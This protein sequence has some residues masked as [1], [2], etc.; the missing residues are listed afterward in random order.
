MIEVMEFAKTNLVS[1]ELKNIQKD[2]NSLGS[3]TCYLMGESKDSRVLMSEDRL[4]ERS[5][6]KIK[7]ELNLTTTE[8]T[9]KE[10]QNV[11]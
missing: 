2:S 11:S 3:P 4:S 5:H 10:V 6:S 8:S 7:S 1:Q 9:P